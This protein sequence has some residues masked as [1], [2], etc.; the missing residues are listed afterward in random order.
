MKKS[1]ILFAAGALAL[2]ACTSEEI[3]DN[4][5]RGNAIGFEHVIN[6]Q[7]RATDEV[8]GDLTTS[9]LDNIYV[10][11][12]YTASNLNATPVQVFDGTEVMKIGG[13]WKYE[14]TRYW[15]PGAKYYFYAYSCADIELNNK[16]GTPTLDLVNDPYR[17]LRF[18]G[19]ICDKN[20]QHDLI[21]ASNEGII[22]H[23]PGESVNE[24]VQ[25]TFS[26]LLTKVNAVFTSDFDSDY[27]LIVSNV[28]IVNIR[29]V[30]DY[31]PVNPESG[32][33]YKWDNVNRNMTNP[34]VMLNMSKSV[35]NKGGD[36]KAYAEAVTSAAYVIPY[37]YS[38]GDVQLCFT[39][40]LRDTQ[41]NEVIM[42]RN[43]KGSWSPNWKLGYSYTYKIK[44]TGTAAN[45][46]EITFGDMN[47][48]GFTGDNNSSTD[49]NITFSMN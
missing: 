41:S 15:V 13:Q 42:S 14:N 30:G 37:N 4:G 22:G 38:N 2:S 32:E 5:V 36:G 35:A 31:T 46:E 11:A 40:Q 48:E 3:V 23:G 39:I 19:F 12:Y 18:T 8:S 45:L 49:V 47:V 44:I 1:L 7:S 9:S 27:D 6:K 28:K 29:N 34:E 26:H 17:S 16:Y 20:H 43:L 24:P 25:F 10:Y 21:Y 33:E